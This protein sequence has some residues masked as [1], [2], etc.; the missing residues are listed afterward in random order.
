MT[1][2]QKRLDKR[3]KKVEA[4]GFV[5]NFAHESYLKDGANIAMVD[6]KVWE[7][8]KFDEVIKK[9]QAYLDDKSGKTM[10]KL[11]KDA[12]AA[13]LDKILTAN[14]AWYSERNALHDA[15]REI[16]LRG[17]ERDQ[18]LDGIDKLERLF[19]EINI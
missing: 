4:M 2:Y 5:W 12:E 16:P 14:E 6:L 19:K 7:D 8:E 10:R 1:D 11:E 17:T 18:L 15:I 9:I 13:R 3:I